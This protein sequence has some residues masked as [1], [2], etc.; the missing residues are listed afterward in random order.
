VWWKKWVFGTSC[1][2][3]ADNQIKRGYRCGFSTLSPPSA[4]KVLL[5]AS[6][7]T[8]LLCSN[9]TKVKDPGSV[10]R[11]Q[12]S[13]STWPY[14]SYQWYSGSSKSFTFLSQ[15]LNIHSLPFPP[16]KIPPTTS[17][18]KTKKN[19]LSQIRTEALSQ[20]TATEEPHLFRGLI[21]QLLL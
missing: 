7:E 8:V 3:L 5:I 11:G 6:M 18:K 9:A 13:S 2:P 21:S 15:D 12:S 14:L 16:L 17:P 1:Q 4:H 10:S 20:P 19:R